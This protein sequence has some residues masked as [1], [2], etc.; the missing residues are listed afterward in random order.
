VSWLVRYDDFSELKRNRTN[1][2]NLPVID[3]R[4]THEHKAYIG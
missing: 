3:W 2:P 4:H 1:Q